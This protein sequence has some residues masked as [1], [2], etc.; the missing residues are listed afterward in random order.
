VRWHRYRG[1]VPVPEPLP[2]DALVVAARAGEAGAFGT[3]FERWFDSV[4]DVA[5]N[6]VRNPETAADVAQDVFL[7]A[8]QRLDTLERPEAFGGWLLR[9]ARNTALNRLA[10]EGR[11]RPLEAAVVTGMHDDGAPDPVGGTPPPG[12]DEQ[13]EANE[14]DQLIA[15]AAAALGERDASLLDLHLRHGLTPSEIADELDITPNNAHQLLFR[16]RGKL[17]NAISASMVWRNG[18]PTCDRLALELAAVDQFDGS[19]V[20]VI[21]QH[22]KTCEDCADDRRA[23]VMPWKLFAAVPIAIAPLAMRARAADALI[24]AGVPMG[25]G[26]GGGGGGAAAGGGGSAAGS[27]ASM[28]A[29]GWIGIAAACVATVGLTVGIIAARDGGSTERIAG[30]ADIPAEVLGEPITTGGAG[31]T[32]A[33]DSSSTPPETTAS[34]STT[35]EPDTAVP[36]IAASTTV[37]PRGAASNVAIATSPVT[38][39]ASTQPQTTS[40]QTTSPTTSPTTTVA[41]TTAPASTM[42]GTTQPPTTVAPTTAPASTVVSTTQPPTTTA[43]P[44]TAPASTV[45]STTQPPTTAATTTTIADTTTSSTTTTTTTTTTTPTTTTV[46]IGGAVIVSFTAGAPPPGDPTQCRFVDHAPRRF[47]WVTVD[48]VSAT[49]TA[50][51]I[52]RVIPPEDFTASGSRVICAASGSTAILSVWAAD[53]TSTSTSIVVDG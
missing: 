26:P 40:P 15:V 11:S 3:L 19:A 32:D 30:S 20:A 45:V 6:I 16:L 4:Y 8:W 7:V 29:A 31:T 1:G 51:D 39:I 35:T 41:P 42:P 34:T 37:A 43:A 23:L 14:R 24:A 53:G 36:A 12:P 9:I 52:V 13:F 44:T 25:G 47:A 10:R 48:A 17:G 49:I 5:R 33:G 27:G 46:P 21:D 28:G 2:D 50:G 18:A 22:S 38:T